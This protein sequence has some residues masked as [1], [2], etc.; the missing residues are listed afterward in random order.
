MVLAWH[1]VHIKLQMNNST[2]RQHLFNFV[3]VSHTYHGRLTGVI[4]CY[5]LQILSSYSVNSNKIWN[6]QM[7]YT[8]LIK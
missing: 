1:D 2:L 6:V 5:I 3:R 4:L 8:E 7:Y